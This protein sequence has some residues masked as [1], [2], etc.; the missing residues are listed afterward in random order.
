MLEKSVSM[1]RVYVVHACDML[2]VVFFVLADGAHVHV[3]VGAWNSL[4]SVIWRVNTVFGPFRFFVASVCM[5][6]FCKTLHDLDEVGVF[7]E[8]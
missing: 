2:M 8:I 1:S 7:S 4:T 6:Q 3:D 5:F